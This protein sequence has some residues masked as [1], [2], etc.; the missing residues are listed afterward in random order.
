S[1]TTVLAPAIAAD[2]K[3]GLAAPPSAMDPHF[4]NLS[5]NNAL[6]SH[7]FDKIVHQDANQGL[8]PG[9]AESWKALDHTTWGFKL[10]K[11]VKCHDG[12]PFTADDVICSFQRAPN[13]P[14]SPSSFGGALKGKTV[15][16][17]DDFTIVVKTKGPQPL[18]P[19]DVSTIAIVSKGAG[20]EGK[21]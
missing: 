9:L 2:L 10:R 17:V 15:E 18:L 11:G 1:L 21:T 8:I 7:I 20:C 3:V 13:V 6:L 5:P 14:N 16:K 4:H 12:A 19:N